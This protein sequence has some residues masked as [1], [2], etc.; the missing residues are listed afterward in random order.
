MLR[1]LNKIE[2]V[3]VGYYINTISSSSDIS[4]GVND[5][6]KS[7]LEK[8]NLKDHINI[9]QVDDNKVKVYYNSDIVLLNP[10]KLDFKISEDNPDSLL[11]SLCLGPISNTI[12]VIDPIFYGKKVQKVYID[13]KDESILVMLNL[14]NYA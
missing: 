10:Y 11:I 4:Y 9:F 8:L 1:E 13:I 14:E 5:F 2:F 3:K 7:D 12:K 6:S